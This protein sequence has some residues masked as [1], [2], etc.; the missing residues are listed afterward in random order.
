MATAAS[1]V[2]RHPF[3]PSGNYVDRPPDKI[4]RI[5]H[6]QL[7]GECGLFQN[8][9]RHRGVASPEPQKAAPAKRQPVVRA[10]RIKV[11]EAELALLAIAVDQAL[12]LP[13]DSLGWKLR[14]RLAEIRPLIEIPTFPTMAVSHVEEAVTEVMTEAVPALKPI[15]R[16]VAP[17][18]KQ[19]SILRGIRHDKVRELVKRAMAQGWSVS[20][21]GSGHIAL[22]KGKQR[23]IMSGTSTGAGRSWGNARSQARKYGIDVTGL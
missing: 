15:A 10:E 7:C 20:K 19:Y 3:I 12:A 9:V 5:W 2:S 11:P 18:G 6:R 23:I 16:P 22:D 8:A 4:G 21:T 1:T 13:A 17:A 14:L